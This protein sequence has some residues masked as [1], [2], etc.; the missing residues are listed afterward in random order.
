[1]KPLLAVQLLHPQHTT[2]GITRR[3]P[4][5]DPKPCTRRNMP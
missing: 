1:L 5:P 3:G 4:R 2:R